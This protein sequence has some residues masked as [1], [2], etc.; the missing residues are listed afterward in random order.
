[1]KTFA[2]FPGCS[3][4]KMAHSY[5]A[6]ALEATRALGIELRELEDWN[7]CGATAYFHVDELLA[8]TLCA[9][10]IAMA[11]KEGLDLVAPCSGC[12]KNMYFTREHL[13]HDADL[14][15]HINEALAEDNLKFQGTSSIRHLIEVFVNDVGLDV[16]R[17]KVTRPLKGLKVAPYYG[18]QIL[19][20]RKGREDVEQPKFFEDLV[21]AIGAEPVDYLLRLSCCSGALI[22][23]NRRAALSMVRNLL[24]CAVR[25]NAAIKAT[26]CPLCQVNLECYQKQV[27][28][29]FGTEL[30]V[31]VVYFTQLVGLAL[32][33]PPKRLGIGSELIDVMPVIRSAIETEPAMASK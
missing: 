11:E 28:H 14:A 23:T 9:R 4:E 16:L 26:A 31:P 2:Y 25:A 7:C 24:E 29:E 20:P 32:G 10:N 13:R 21:R 8:F 17:S 19:R 22:I 3:L 18:C 33:I 15:E 30:N 27:N 1:M 12:Y 5:H 6:S